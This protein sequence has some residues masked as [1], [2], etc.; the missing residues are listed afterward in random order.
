ME[1][2]IVL[3]RGPCLSLVTRSR[4]GEEKEDFARHRAKVRLHAPRMRSFPSRLALE[5]RGRVLEV[6]SFLTEDDRRRLAARLRAMVGGTNESPPLYID[7]TL[8][9]S[10]R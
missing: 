8:G 9:D 10:L 4:H 6:G 5:N 7:S 3:A 2:R 1:Q